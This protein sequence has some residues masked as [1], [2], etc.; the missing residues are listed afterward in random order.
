MTKKHLKVSSL[1]CFALLICGAGRL[2]GAEQIL[3]ERMDTDWAKVVRGF[4][5]DHNFSA[6]VALTQNRWEGQTQ[7]IVDRFTAKTQAFELQLDYSFHLPLIWKLGYVLGTH[8]GIIFEEKDTRGFAL[9]RTYILPGMELGLVWN[10]NEWLRFMTS[11]RYGWQRAENMTLDKNPREGVEKLAATGDTKSIKV[12]LDYFVEIS[13]AIRIEHE[14][15]DFYYSAK[16]R[17]EL[18]KTSRIVRLG[19]VKHL[20]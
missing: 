10:V 5:H 17:F 9:A 7:K 4:R 19:L 15:L 3:D 18:L 6:T 1:F 2:S 16:E 12:A 13:T 14:T 20:L 8:T 11:Y